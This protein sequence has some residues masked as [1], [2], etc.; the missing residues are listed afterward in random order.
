M[1]NTL[2]QSVYCYQCIRFP[3]VTLNPVSGVC[4]KCFPVLSDHRLDKE[5]ED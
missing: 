3:Q 2:V 4:C 5:A 1:K